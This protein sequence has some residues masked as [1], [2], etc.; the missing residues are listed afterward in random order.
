VIDTARL[1]PEATIAGLVS[2]AVQG[3][4]L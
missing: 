2:L 4:S 1:T 3:G